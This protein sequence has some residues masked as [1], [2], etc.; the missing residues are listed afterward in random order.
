MNRKSNR[1]D[2]L[3]A[4]TQLEHNDN[5]L[6]SA[7]Q[8]I[9]NSQLQL[10]GVEALLRVRD[11]EN[12]AVYTPDF[13]QRFEGNKLFEVEIAVIFLHISNF[14]TQPFP[15]HTKLFLNISPASLVSFFH[16]PLFQK[17]LDKLEREKITTDQI[18][19][20]V[21]E[22]SYSKPD[23]LTEIV[24]NLKKLGFQ[25]AIDD[26]GVE[27]S[28]AGRA[29]ELQPNIIKCDQ[30]ILQ[31]FITGHTQ[32]LEQLI[33]L[34]KEINSE[35]LMEGIEQEVYFN[36]LKQ[37]DIAFFQGFWIGKPQ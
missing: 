21:L 9:V 13:L 37:L 10:F 31:K 16:N 20:E 12:Q 26:Y 36:R 33:S 6:S 1:V 15:I 32:P 34:S 14:L 4:K 7:F 35:L 30:S 18:C 19:F 8:P 22:Y 24:K 28:H 3:S 23:Y 25:I 27:A 29:S 5:M 2:P 11:T 17:L